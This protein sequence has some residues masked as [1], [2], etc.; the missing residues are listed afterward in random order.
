M[1]D[2]KVEF[3]LEDVVY[4]GLNGFGKIKS[5]KASGF[6][7]VCKNSRL[8]K[9]PLNGDIKP[10]K[11]MRAEVYRVEGDFIF[12]DIFKSIFPKKL[13]E[14]C[15]SQ[16]EIIEFCEKKRDFLSDPNIWITAF[17]IKIKEELVVV[18]I[19]DDGF[20]KL[21]LDTYDIKE[22]AGAI[23]G[24]YHSFIVVPCF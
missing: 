15:F 22:E 8:P 3:E 13:E 9:F 14:A 7:D 2:A 16:N 24:S 12:E 4:L 20:G 21:F 1:I 11:D 10:N 19:E 18:G 17:L 5:S 23:L 6:F